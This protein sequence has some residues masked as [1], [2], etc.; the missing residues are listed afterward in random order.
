MERLINRRQQGDLG[1]A[2][3]IEWLSRHG[4]V[5]AVPFGHSPDFDLVAQI[6]ERLLRVQ[7]KT[8][9]QEVQT[10]NG[11]LRFSVALVTCGGNQSWTGVAKLFDPTKV[12]Y[13]FALTSNGRRWFIPAADLEGRRAINLGGDKYAEYEIEPTTPIRQLVYDQEAA[14]ESDPPP[15][16]YPSGQRGG[17]VNAM[18]LPSQVRILP[19]PSDSNESPEPRALGRTRMSSNHQVTVPL[20]V[21]AAASIEPG[22]R[23]RVE[24]DGTGRFV[25]TRI[26]EYR[27]QHA[28]QL[29]LPSEAR[30]PA[31]PERR[32]PD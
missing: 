12:D 2:S 1:E 14:L 30:E 15:G 5:V 16:E 32:A 25:M 20:A 21:A 29:S 24:S 18:A 8:S 11:H 13:L 26:E 31:G 27:E 3:A 4:A 28:A 23:F 19:P 9:T 10:P 17:A 7:V 22:D 6:G